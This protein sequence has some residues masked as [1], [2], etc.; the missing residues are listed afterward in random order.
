[1][2]KLVFLSIAFCLVASMAFAQ[3]PKAAATAAATTAT[4][5][6]TVPAV[7]PATVTLTGTIIDNMCA[8]TQKP[9]ELTAFIKTHTKE[10]ALKCASS[11]Y[12]IFADGKLSKFDKDSNVKVEEFLKKVDSKTDVVVVAQVVNGELSLVSIDNQPVSK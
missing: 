2:K 8:G 5:P 10:C 7:E 6:E 9:E 11:G 3:A 1:M 12:A 4:T